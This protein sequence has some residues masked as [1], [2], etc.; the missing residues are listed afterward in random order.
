MVRGV[1]FQSG[2]AD[3]GW[4]TS[5]KMWPKTSKT[6]RKK[7]VISEVVREEEECYKIKATYD[8]LP[9][10]QNL[11]L[12]YGSEEISQL[13]GYQNSSLQHTLS[14]CKTAL[15]QGLYGRRHDQ[16]LRSHRKRRLEANRASPATTHGLIQFVRQGGEALGSSTKEWSLLSPGGNWELRVDLDHQLK[17]PQQIDVTSLQP[18]IVLWSAIARTVIMVELTVP[19]EDGLDSA[20][21]RKKEK[22]ADLSAACTEAGWNA[23]IYPVE[24]VC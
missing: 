1:R 5:P 16:V 3:L 7:L 17:F 8:T 19:W 2:R 13:C 11:H 22:Y 23:F 14:S 20:F 9:S 10:P 4:G 24:V 12:W 6:E 21:E 18:D 15:T